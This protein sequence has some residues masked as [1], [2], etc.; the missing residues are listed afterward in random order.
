MVPLHLLALLQETGGGG[1]GGGGFLQGLEQ[2]QALADVETGGGGSLLEH[3]EV[4]GGGGNSLLHLLLGL[5]FL[6]E[7]SVDGVE[8]FGLPLGLVGGGL[9]L[10][11]G[12]VLGALHAVVP[13]AALLQDGIFSGLH[14]ADVSADYLGSVLFDSVV[15]ADSRGQQEHDHQCALHSSLFICN[16][17]FHTDR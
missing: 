1:N 15:T 17:I 10:D 8:D 7:V 4:V 12:E 13:A 6:G 14:V 11:V 3:G 2:G 5:V 16:Y 9:L